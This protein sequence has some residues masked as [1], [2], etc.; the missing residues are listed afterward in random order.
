MQ[1]SLLA[2]ANKAQDRKYYRFLNLQVSRD[3][4]PFKLRGPLDVGPTRAAT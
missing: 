3:S 2:I 4:S 1:T